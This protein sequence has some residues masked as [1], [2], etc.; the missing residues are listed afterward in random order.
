[1]ENINIGSLDQKIKRHSQHSAKAPPEFL[2]A[3]LR[4]SINMYIAC[5]KNRIPLLDFDIYFEDVRNSLEREYQ[6][7]F[8]TEKFMDN[9]QPTHWWQFTYAGCNAQIE[10]FL[11]ENGFGKA[12][13]TIWDVIE[14]SPGRTIPNTALPDTLRRYLIEIGYLFPQENAVIVHPNMLFGQL[15]TETTYATIDSPFLTRDLIRCPYHAEIQS[16]SSSWNSVQSS[17]QELWGYWKDL[18]ALSLVRI[19]E[20]FLYTPKHFRKEEPLSSEL[21]RF[22]DLGRKFVPARYVALEPGIEAFAW[23][24]SNQNKEIA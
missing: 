23:Y 15:T 21:Q 1:M 3:E 7:Y 10:E 19:P 6:C 17:D 4:R 2:D 13:E 18:L 16:W 22:L 8:E 11:R 24:F 14:N 20:H 9:L 5:N 12:L